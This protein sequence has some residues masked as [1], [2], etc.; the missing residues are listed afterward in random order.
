ME[1]INGNTIE[2]KTVPKIYAK[3]EETGFKNNTARIMTKE[4]VKAVFKIIRTSS[5][6]PVYNKIIN[7]STGEFFYKYIRDFSYVKIKL[8]ELQT[9]YYLGVFTWYDT[10]IEVCSV[11]GGLDRQLEENGKC[12]KGVFRRF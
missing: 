7:S 8:P 4:E 1:I 6:S 5:L 9:S 2:F 10:D 12:T 3:E 11:C